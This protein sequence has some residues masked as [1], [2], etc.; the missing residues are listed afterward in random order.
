MTHDNG[1]PKDTN[2]APAGHSDGSELIPAEV[3][4]KQV[5]N[6]PTETVAVPGTTVDDEGLINNFATEPKVYPATYPS[7]SKQRQ[8]VVWGAAALAFVALLLFV[9]KSVS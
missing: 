9:A 8:Y 6:A 4:A 3:Q 1:Q 7:P 2:V 5:D